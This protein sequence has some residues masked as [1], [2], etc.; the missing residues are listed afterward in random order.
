MKKYRNFSFF[1]C[2]NIFMSQTNLHDFYDSESTKID[3]DKVPVTTF[4]FYTFETRT[5]DHCWKSS[6]QSSLRSEVAVT[7]LTELGTL[8][9]NI[10]LFA[11]TAEIQRRL[12]LFILVIPGGHIRDELAIH[13]EQQWYRGGRPLIRRLQVRFLPSLPMC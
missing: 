5:S 4:S 8:F 11:I 7:F 2:L 6:C 9:E 1:I 10:D 13:Y 3:S 12:D